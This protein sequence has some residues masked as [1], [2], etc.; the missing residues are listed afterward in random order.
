MTL[1]YNTVLKEDQQL[2]KALQNSKQEKETMASRLEFLE[3]QLAETEAAVSETYSS[4]NISLLNQYEAMQRDRNDNKDFIIQLQMKLLQSQEESEKRT[5][6][7]RNYLFSGQMSAHTLFRQSFSCHQHFNN[8]KTI[9]RANH[10]PSQHML[11]YEGRSSTWSNRSRAC[12]G[13][14]CCHHTTHV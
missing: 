10:P 9:W 5:R 14:L 7:V 8:N 13:A 1:R 2:V 6:E 4:A 11:N 3:E 12:K